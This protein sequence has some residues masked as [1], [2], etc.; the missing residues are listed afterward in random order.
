MTTTFLNHT[1]EEWVPQSP[2]KGPPFPVWENVYWPWY[3][4]GPG[5][6]PTTGVVIIV[7]VPSNAAI[8]LNGQNVTSGVSTSLAAGT[9]SYSI[10]ASGYTTATGTVTVVAGQT[11]TITKTLASTTGGTGIVVITLSPSNAIFDINGTN[12]SSGNSTLPAGTYSYTAFASGYTTKTGSV[13]VT[14]GHTTTLNITLSSSTSMTPKFSVGQTIKLTGYPIT[15]KYLITSISGG[16]YNCNIVGIPGYT[17]S[18][19]IVDQDDYELVTT[20]TTAKYGVGQIVEDQWGDEFLI[21]SIDTA[22][23][24]YN[25]ILLPSGGVTDLPI[26]DVDASYTLV[27]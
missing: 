17:Y 26:A 2:I 3:K 14:A 9:Y 7:A 13:T 22:N 21:T 25:C 12:Y 27:S 19:D 11:Q 5:P 4:A 23:G 8:V 18:I 24:Y 6:T 1:L 10:S 20:T 15:N 16:K